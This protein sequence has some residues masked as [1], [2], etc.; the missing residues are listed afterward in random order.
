M[1]DV[2]SG[3]RMWAYVPREFGAVFEQ[4]KN[5]G[6]VTDYVTRERLL[7]T[8]DIKS[9]RER[10][11]FLFNNIRV[12]SDGQ[13]PSPEHL[14]KAV[15]DAWEEELRFAADRGDLSRED[16]RGTER[17]MK[18]M[19]AVSASARAMEMSAGNASTYVKRITQT[20]DGP[21]KPDL[22]KKD[23]WADVLLHGD[24]EKLKLVTS[25]PLVR[26]F[27]GKII[28][29]T[30]I[31]GVEWDE[32]RGEWK[33]RN[34]AVTAERAR[35]GRLLAYLATT[36][37]YPEG[38]PRNGAWEKKE[39][40]SDYIAEVLLKPL[41]EEDQWDDEIREFLEY[42]WQDEFSFGNEH[43]WAA[44]RLAADAF[45]V[46]QYTLWEYEIDIEGDFKL[47]PRPQWGGNP[48]RAILEPSFLPRRI[49]EMYPDDEEV[50]DMVD[51]AFRPE[52]LVEGT[53]RAA[54]MTRD[55]ER[56]DLEKVLL[57]R[58]SMTI[59]LK[60]FAR[61][62]DALSIFFGGSRCEMIP[63]WNKE[64]IEGGLQSTLE[65][66]D[67]VYGKG[68]DGEFPDRM[69]GRHVMGMITARILQCKAMAS[70][71]EFRE[72]G[73]GSRM[74]L[75]FGEAKE[76][77]F[78]GVRQFIWGPKLETG[79]M[80]GERGLLDS[81]DGGRTRFAFRDNILGAQRELRETSDLLI[82]LQ[83]NPRSRRTSK[84]LHDLGRGWKV[85]EALATSKR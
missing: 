70:A 25:H 50:F 4:G 24:P 1:E 23:K 15:V 3:E 66:L 19:M 64:V 81:L 47:K 82:S 76:Q 80:I 53:M 77:P 13:I 21:S 31:R 44:A 78:F 6:R 14:W 54:G 75:L 11:A 85:V 9:A 69:L 57:L 33:E 38:D 41:F 61:Y 22:D 60:A 72:E 29:D 7:P 26:Y 45:L 40:F 62:S 63:A 30:G 5:V 17:Q 27:Y 65:L 20:P 48:L 35:Q 67:Q 71:L 46:D 52:D 56:T 36:N 59:P 55:R 16:L 49:K 84:L 10:Q 18:A 79:N 74:E 8:Y 42:C 39:G 73:F 34:W 68:I 32:A 28:D 83:E 37:P 51:G 43:L 58:P 2:G 12:L